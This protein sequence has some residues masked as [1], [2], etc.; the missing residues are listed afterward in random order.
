M[1]GKHCFTPSSCPLAGDT[2]PVAE[3]AH[4][5]GNCSITGG[6]VYRGRDAGRTLVGHYVFADF[7]SGR[8][9]TM[10]HDGGTADVVLRA[11]TAYNIT[12]FGENEARRAL[13]P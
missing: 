3:Y 11:D 2:L 13:S 8:I 10:P 12:S 4:A 6:F 5:G 1:E 7:C 9:W